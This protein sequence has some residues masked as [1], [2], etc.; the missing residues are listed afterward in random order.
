M[1][2]V[3]DTTPIISLMKAELLD[4]LEKMFGDVYI[5]QAVYDEL[6]SN[7]NYPVEAKLVQNSTFIKVGA[8]Q[9]AQSVNKLMCEAGLDLGE[10]E[11][12][13]FAMEQNADLL[14]M[15]EHKGRQTAQKM[16]ITITGTVGILLQAYDEGLIDAGSIWRS[17]RE[18][19]KNNMR[20]G[21]VFDTIIVEHIGKEKDKE[22]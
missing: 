22:Q 9:N 16:G 3:S 8:V 2:I 13:V 12:L 11:A 20:I 14:L 17:V 7:P 10:C 19:R 4:L 21:P 1:L 15:D 5:P 6:T 18:M